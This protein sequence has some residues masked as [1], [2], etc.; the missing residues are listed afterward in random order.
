MPILKT[1]SIYTIKSESGKS[2]TISLAGRNAWALE[3]LASAGATGC[4]PIDQSAPRW[5]AYVVN[6]CALGVPIE[7]VTE[8]HDGEYAGHHGRYVLRARVVKGGVS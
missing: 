8:P 7:T 6:L 4:T 1:K 5:S 2:I 3:Q